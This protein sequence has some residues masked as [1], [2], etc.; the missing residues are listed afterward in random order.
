MLD[1]YDIKVG[2]RVRRYFSDRASDH[3]RPGTVIHVFTGSLDG[4]VEITWDDGTT[5]IERSHTLRKA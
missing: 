2:A 4:A 5:S 3:Q 1:Y